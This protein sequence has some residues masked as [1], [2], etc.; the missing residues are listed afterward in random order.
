MNRYK[1]TVNDVTK[2]YPEG[3]VYG[4]IVKDFQNQEKYPI[5]L[6]VVNGRLRELHKTLKQDA[7]ISFVTTADSI[8]HKTYKRSASLLFLKAMYHV[9]GRE[10]L[11]QI[12][13]NF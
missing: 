5:V 9:V 12:I 13:L 4:E 8:G 7:N 1:V 6:V 2:E 10:N 3:T 11:K